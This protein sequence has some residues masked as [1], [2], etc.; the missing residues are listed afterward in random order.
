[1]YYLLVKFFLGFSPSGSIYHLQQEMFG[2]WVPEICLHVQYVYEESVSHLILSM[3]PIAVLYPLGKDLSVRSLM[4]THWSFSHLHSMIF[5][6][7]SFSSLFT[8][9]WLKGV[10]ASYSL[11]CPTKSWP[12]VFGRHPKASSRI[13]WKFSCRYYIIEQN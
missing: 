8:L 7:S 4:K 10:L 5:P 9:I 13:T 6:L 2:Y 1:M 12:I 11:L 3:T